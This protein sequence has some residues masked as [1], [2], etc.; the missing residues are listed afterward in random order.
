LFEKIDAPLTAGLLRPFR[1]DQVLAEGKR[2]E[3]DLFYQ[4]ICG[5]LD[6]LLQAVASSLRREPL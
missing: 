5:D 2:C 3:L 1:G 4:R 6:A